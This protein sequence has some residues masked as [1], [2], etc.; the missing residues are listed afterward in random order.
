MQDS[1]SG[2]DDNLDELD[3]EPVFTKRN[4]DPEKNFE[5]LYLR[6]ATKEFANDLE[7]LRNA[8]DFKDKSVPML[9]DALKQ[10]TACFSREEREKIGKAVSISSA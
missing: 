7:K 2:E 3:A 6:Q 1:I 8:S 10:G 5:E 4:V 9:V